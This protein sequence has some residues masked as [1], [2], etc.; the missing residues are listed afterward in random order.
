MRGR[1]AGRPAGPGPR[2][3]LIRSGAGT[4]PLD[5]YPPAIDA[6]IGLGDW[7]RVLAYVDALTAF[8]GEERVG[9]VDILIRRA[10]LIAS[11]Y[12]GTADPS[13]LADLAA[14]LRRMGYAAALPA[15]QGAMRR[16][17]APVRKEGDAGGIP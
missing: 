11:V 13:A 10:R 17:L 14:E 6:A 5:F 2:R 4:Y 9:L 12:L 15:L 3:A 7:P 8:F 1:P 16:P